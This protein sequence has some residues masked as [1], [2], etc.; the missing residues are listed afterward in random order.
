MTGVLT[1]KWQGEDRDTGRRLRDDEGREGVRQLPGMPSIAGKPRES[2]K[3]QGG[4][5]PCRC[6]RGHGSVGT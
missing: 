4:S 3:S 1:G 2:R 6:Q 5:F